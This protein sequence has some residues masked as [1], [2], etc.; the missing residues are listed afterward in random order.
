MDGAA[1]VG[2]DDAGAGV[3]AGAGGAAAV[4]G[5]VGPAAQFVLGGAAAS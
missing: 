2:A 4:D 5:A 3:A 1:V